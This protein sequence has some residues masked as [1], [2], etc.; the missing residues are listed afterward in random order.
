MADHASSSTAGVG[1]AARATAWG[2]NS[3][4]RCAPASAAATGPRRM[5]I[6]CQHGTYMVAKQ[7][8]TCGQPT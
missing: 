1:P 6:A 3:A 2:A 7:E 8:R 4:P 5:G